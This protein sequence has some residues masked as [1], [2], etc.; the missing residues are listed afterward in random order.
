MYSIKSF[1]KDLLKSP[2]FRKT[3][4]PFHT[5]LALT[6][7]QLKLLDQLLERH[8]LGLQKKLC[9]SQAQR[10]RN[11]PRKLATRFGVSSRKEGFQ[12]NAVYGGGGVFNAAADS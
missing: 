4:A 1:I 11:G 6:N 10:R 5:S 12:H 9:F 8:C 3:N 2:L 7:F